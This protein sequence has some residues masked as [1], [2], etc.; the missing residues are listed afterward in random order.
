MP[1]K[2]TEEQPS[3][4][5]FL[6]IQGAGEVLGIPERSAY[7]LVVVKRK[8]PAVKWGEGRNARWYVSRRHLEEFIRQMEAEAEAEK[9]RVWGAA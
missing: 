8:I 1:A 6:S 9:A 5:R 7:D 2:Q 4:G 3:A